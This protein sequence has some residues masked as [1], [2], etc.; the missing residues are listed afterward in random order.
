MSDPEFRK[1]DL[2]YFRYHIVPKFEALHWEEVGRDKRYKPDLLWEQ[3]ELLEKLGMLHILA[4]LLDGAPEGYFVG[5]LSPHLHYRKMQIFLSDMFY[6]SEKCRAMHGVKLFR[7]AEKMARA[8]GAHKMHVVYKTYKSIEPIMRRLKF[9][10]VE[11]V[12]VKN[13]EA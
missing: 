8:V 2:A 4:M 6:M 1:V 13:L 10:Q 5:I 7:E 3:Y 9:Q 12:A 11:V